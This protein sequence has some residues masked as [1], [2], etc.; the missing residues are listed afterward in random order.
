MECGQT[1][2][3]TRDRVIDPAGCHDGAQGAAKYPV[4][5]GSR[6]RLR[7]LLDRMAEPDTTQ[8]EPNALD[9]DFH[10]E[11]AEWGATG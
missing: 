10:M 2:C 7:A 3:N 5:E 1:N 9:S 8:D 11:L 6:D 4:D